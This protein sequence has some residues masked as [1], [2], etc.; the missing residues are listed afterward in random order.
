MNHIQIWAILHCL[1]HGAAG[2]GNV[3]CWLSS[4][5]LLAGRSMLLKIIWRRALIQVRR[6]LLGCH[7]IVNST[8]TASVWC[9]TL[10]LLV[11]STLTR[12]ALILSLLNVR[13]SSLVMK[14]FLGIQTT[15]T[16]IS[17]YSHAFSLWIISHAHWNHV[18]RCLD[19]RTGRI[20]LTMGSWWLISTL[21]EALSGNRGF[22]LPSNTFLN[23]FEF[24]ILMW[25][26]CALNVSWVGRSNPC[27]CLYPH[28]RHITAFRPMRCIFQF[29]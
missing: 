26:R 17:S 21:S 10:P 5:A 19:L 18:Y 12:I 8:V 16:M 2:G 11:E 4:S 15:L 13:R 22:R 25:V 1:P 6:R 7:S 3:S 14:S 27:T 29:L 9:Y 28:W 24:Q 23:I 20:E